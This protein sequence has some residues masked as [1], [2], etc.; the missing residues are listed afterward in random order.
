MYSGVLRT[1]QTLAASLPI[2]VLEP[3]QV[4]FAAGE[5]GGSVYCVLNGEIELSWGE[6]PPEVFG[7][8][9]VLGVGALVEQQHKRHGTASARVATE[10]IEMDREHFLFAVQE[11]PMFALELMASLEGRLRHLEQ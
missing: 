6:A 9:D 1:M 8:G 2:R 10:V 4:L 7:P 11:M 3:G 5:N